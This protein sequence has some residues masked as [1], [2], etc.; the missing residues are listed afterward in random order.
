[1]CISLVTLV[2]GELE[3][4]RRDVGMEWEGQTERGRGGASCRVGS[5]LTAGLW[6][7]GRGSKT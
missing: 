5:T 3:R 1:M 4:M 6:R 2:S 7:L